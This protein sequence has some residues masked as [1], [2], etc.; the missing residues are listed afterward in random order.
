M[1]QQTDQVARRT[2]EVP[3]T[4]CRFQR[5]NVELLPD[6][7]GKVLSGGGRKC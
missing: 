5:Q 3:L 4:T 6:N 2:G 1:F 7:E